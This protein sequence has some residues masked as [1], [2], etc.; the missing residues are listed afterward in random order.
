VPSY[1]ARIQAVAILIALGFATLTIELV[2]R[3]KLNEWYSLIWLV[4]GGLVSAFAIFRNLQFVLAKAVGLYYPP[5]L[6]LGSLLF[7]LLGITLYLSVVVTRLEAQNR[8][9]AQRLALLE[10]RH[11]ALGAREPGGQSSP[12]ENRGTPRPAAN[13]DSAIP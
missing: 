7:M 10:F 13:A 9:L 11:R 6:I 2:R 5:I 4:T 1:E 8:R 3:R 12:E